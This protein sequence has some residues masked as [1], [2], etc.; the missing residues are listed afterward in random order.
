MFLLEDVEHVATLIHGDLQAYLAKRAQGKA[1]GEEYNGKQLLDELDAAHAAGDEEG[2][3][4][5]S[6]ELFGDI[7]QNFIDE[8]LPDL[9]DLDWMGPPV[10]SR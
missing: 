5:L 4:R 8:V 2:V 6:D 1:T 3:Q 7:P 10:H 9:Q